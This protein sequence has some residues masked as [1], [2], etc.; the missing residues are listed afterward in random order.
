LT[1]PPELSTSWNEAFPAALQAWSALTLLRNPLL[2]SSE[3]DL[4]RERVRGQIAA[5]RLTDATILVNAQEIVA[6]GLEPFALAIL[7]HE[8]GHHVYVP[9]SLRDHGILLAALTRALSGLR[10]SDV[11]LAA[12]LYGDLLIN[13][14]LQRRAGI[15]MADVFRALAAGTAGGVSDT[16]TL[17]CRTYEH[18]WRLDPGTIAPAPVTEE[19]DADAVLV[20]RIVRSFGGEWL[21]GARQFGLVLYPYLARD[22]AR[23]GVSR[24]VL[25]GLSDTDRPAGAH[26]V[27]AASI[28]DGLTACDA[29]ELEQEPDGV[30]K[31]APGGAPGSQFRQPFE[32]GQLLKSLGLDL[33]EHEV[34]T[35]YYRELALPHI[36]PFPRTPAPISLEPQA[37]GNERWE[38][39]DPLESLDILASVLQSPLVIPGVTTVQPVFSAVPGPQPAPAP[40]DLDI[41]VDCSGS[42]PDPSQSLSYLAL[43]AT[44]L[45]LSAL[46]AGAR[47]QATLWSSAGVFE[48]TAG[49]LRDERRILGIVT[50]YVSGGTAFPIHILRETYA[51]RR[52]SDSPVHIVVISD[53][54]ADTMLLT[55]EKG[56]DGKVVCAEA[57]VRA[58]GGGTL[59]LNMGDLAHWRAGEP[60]EAM[61]YHIHA[62]RVWADLV[63]FAR[64]FVRECYGPSRAGAPLHLR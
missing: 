17:I 28:P 53:D 47:V 41:Y 4:T 30:K 12:N 38:P 19:L 42:M 20:A 34:R 14:R 27:D 55:D 60:L 40:V 11:H 10:A 21:M 13:D 25:L 32:Y 49:F 15:D 18:L 22:A 39:G 51:G 46:R 26:S 48:T 6:R 54:G 33:S 62:V 64:A 35:R 23:E 5:I 52:P 44:I 59:V 36:I 61:G 56:N 1:L 58:R 8:V 31:G 50:G 37:E 7:A 9:A 43:A 45:S 16:W 29:A 24:F 2:L 63:A 57:M 3:E